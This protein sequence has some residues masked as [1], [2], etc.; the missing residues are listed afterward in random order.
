MTGATMR[1]GLMRFFRSKNRQLADRLELIAVLLVLAVV[2]VLLIFKT[3]GLLS[4]LDE[5]VVLLVQ[6]IAGL[7]IIAGFVLKTFEARILRNIN[8]ESR[9]EL[10]QGAGE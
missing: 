5:R 3:L 9:M 4:V 1:T 8:D 7:G 6:D 10:E 2:L